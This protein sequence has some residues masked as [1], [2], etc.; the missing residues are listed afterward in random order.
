MGD[1]IFR[2]CFLDSF[3][4]DALA[5]FAFETLKAK[6]VAIMSDVSSAYSLGLAEYFQT[7]FKKKGG[8]VS[9]E[10]KYSK[11]DTDFNAQLTAIKTT[12]PDA[13]FVPGYY[14]EVGLV[15]RQARQLGITV[16]LFGGDGWE[17]PELLQIAKE[18]AE[19][20]YYTT[21]YSPETQTP[22]VQNFVKAYRAKYNDTPDAM[23]ALGYDSAL[24][25]VDAIKRAGTTEGPKL[26]D[27]IAATDGLKGVTGTTRI[28]Q[29][30]DATKPATVITIKGGKFQYVDTIQPEP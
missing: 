27:A 7:S 26:R 18:A 22:E 3:Q 11:N 5:R 9:S 30:R 29:N 17:A 6:K 21:H 1:Y 14:Q 2:V 25:L 13:I 15:I 12:A 8:T 10:Q 19:G 4:G 23:A 24:V 16:P 28:D 20:T